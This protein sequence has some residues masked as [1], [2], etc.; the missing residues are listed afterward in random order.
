M[1]Q[2]HDLKIETCIYRGSDDAGYIY[3]HPFKSIAGLVEET[4]PLDVCSLNVD[5]GHDGKV[6][7]V[8]ILGH[9]DIF[10]EMHKAG[11]I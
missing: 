10:S 3:F 2:I 8:E 11:V 1:V 5:V 7:G 9:P 6:L 4:I